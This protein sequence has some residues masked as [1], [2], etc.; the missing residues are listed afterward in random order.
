MVFTA[1][2]D[3]RCW[4]TKLVV[5][6]RNLIEAP[7][8]KFNLSTFTIEDAIKFAPMGLLLMHIRLNLVK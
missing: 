7:S 4:E 2:L 8:H 5:V 1:P 3:G 6:N